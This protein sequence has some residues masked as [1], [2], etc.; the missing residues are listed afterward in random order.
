MVR[1][2]PTQGNKRQE[3]QLIL[4]ETRSELCR[5]ALWD[6]F[7]T[8]SL[9]LLAIR[10]IEFETVRIHFLGEFSVCGHPEI[11]LP[12]ERDVTTSPLYYERSNID[13]GPPL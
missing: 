12:W 6:C 10:S 9:L 4:H 8:L 7:G 11:L 2:H 3:I 13:L 5:I 1:L